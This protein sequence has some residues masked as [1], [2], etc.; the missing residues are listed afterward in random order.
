[1]SMNKG[2]FISY[3]ANE[4]GCSKTEASKIIDTFANK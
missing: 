1:M 3:I 2:E 4:H